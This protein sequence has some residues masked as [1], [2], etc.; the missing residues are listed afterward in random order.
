[1]SINFS[2]NTLVEYLE[3]L[4]SRQQVPGGGS[5][6]ALTAS[7]GAGLVSMVAN[8]SIGRKTN[9]KALDA[10]FTK[11]ALKAQAASKRLLLLTSLDSEA[12]LKVAKARALDVKAQRVAAK[13]ARGVPAE[14]C[15]ISYQLVQ[16]T[17][18]L[19]EKGN[20]YLLSDVEVAVELLM[21]AFNGAKVMVRI[22][23]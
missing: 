23:S 13:D 22:N 12:Y 7:L 15:K 8:Y 1:M 2:K 20:P 19:V 9:T 16:M 14:V 17:P 21:A 6:A 5:A 3:Q 10:K 11:I 18:L 4:S